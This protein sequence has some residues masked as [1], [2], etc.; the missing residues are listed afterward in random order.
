MRLRSRSGL[1]AWATAAIV[2]AAVAY[3]TYNLR[4][5]LG[6]P[7]L[8][9]GWVLLVLMV[10]LAF[11]NW[12]KKLSMIPLGRASTWLA[13]H[14]AGGLLAI[15]VFFLHTGTVWPSG[16]YEEVLAVLFYLTSIS[17]IVGLCFERIYPRRLTHAD[18]EI[19]YERIPAE[20]AEM[21][22]AAE[23]IVLDCTADTG[24]DTLA[25]HYL[26]TLSWYFRRPRFALAYLVGSD[27]GDHWLRQEFAAVSRYLNDAERKFLDRLR[28][29]GVTK[30]RV[31]RHYAAQTVLKYWLLFHVPLAA[32]VMVITVWHVLLVH[33]YAV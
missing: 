22:E 17:G 6:R 9:T 12:R 33:V 11:L 16:T 7:I 14:V 21:R 23:K 28:D 25:R 1:M 29:L 4:L 20:I 10:G 15:G 3:Q 19:I 8:L 2:F 26:D 13:L 32:S 31:D 30:T 5:H 18:Y 27:H 24:S